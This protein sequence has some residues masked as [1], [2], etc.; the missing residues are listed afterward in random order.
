MERKGYKM[1][2]IK[3]TVW[4]KENIWLLD[5]EKMRIRKCELSAHENAIEYAKL[6]IDCMPGNALDDIL[7]AISNEIMPML[8]SPDK[9]EIL[10][11]SYDI[12]NRVRI[13]LNVLA[14]ERI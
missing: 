6:I 5:I 12:Q 14:N 8:Q 9:I 2:T 4:N 13:A 7:D 10:K 1:K 11:S 3:L